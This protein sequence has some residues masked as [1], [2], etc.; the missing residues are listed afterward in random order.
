MED[1]TELNRKLDKINDDVSN[2]KIT[3]ASKAQ[4]EINL[5]AN[6]DR[7]WS[8]TWPETVASIDANRTKIA[9]HGIQLAKIN[10]KLTV[11]SAIISVLVPLLASAVLY[12]LRKG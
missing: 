2:I 9:E 11:F 1:L 7:F 5:T 12:Y 8:K 4:A 10:T 6:I 3:L